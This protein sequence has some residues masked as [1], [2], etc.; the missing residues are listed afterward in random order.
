MSS[1]V[2][3]CGE[4]GSGLGCKTKTKPSSVKQEFS[5]KLPMVN[6]SRYERTETGAALEPIARYYCR[7]LAV[8]GKTCYR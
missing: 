1:T 6:L 4:E 5:T 8:V 3:A 2:V 7:Y